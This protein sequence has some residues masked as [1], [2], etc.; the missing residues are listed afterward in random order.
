[1]RT[2]KRPS[3]N[4]LR[5]KKILVTGGTGFIGSHL[6]DCLQFA[7]AEVHATSRS[8]QSRQTDGPR[9]WPID[10][11]EHE[12]VR[13]LLQSIKPDIIFHLAGH[14]EG[15]RALGLVIPTFRNSL[16]STVNLLTAAAE[17]GCLKFVLTGSMEE[18]EGTYNETDPCSPYAAA[19]WACSTYSRMFF[20]LFNLPV[21]NLRLFMVYGP[22][23]KDQKKIIPYVIQSLLSG[24]APKLGSGRREIDWIYVEDVVSALLFAS[25]VAGLE[26]ETIDVGS[27][28]RFTIRTVVEKLVEIVDPRIEPAFGALPD[29]PFEQLRV[30]DVR[31][32]LERMNWKPVFS[33][34]EGL[35]LTVEWYAKQAKSRQERASC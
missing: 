7:E 29:R 22:D 12:E 16:M 34:E 4:H 25:Q 18:P 26:G 8:S 9:W 6:L 32:S 23:Q 15:A 24:E 13:S 21:I 31:K 27:G 14:V 11:A 1:M 33:L 10:L 3:L 28:E 20:R 35:K 17:V 30:A 19:K 2:E 5:K